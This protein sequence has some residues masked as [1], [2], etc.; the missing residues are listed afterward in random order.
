MSLLNILHQQYI[1]HYA[2]WQ[3]KSSQTYIITCIS[4]Q[5]MLYEGRS[6][7][8]PMSVLTLYASAIKHIMLFY[9]RSHVTLTSLFTLYTIS[10]LHMLHK[11][12]QSFA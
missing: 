9:G 12:P 10:I 4:C 6:H 2:F 8:A 1:L 7:L 5:K 11:A 3:Y